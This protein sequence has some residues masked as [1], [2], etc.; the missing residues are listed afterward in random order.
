MKN[1]WKEILN[2]YLL[3]PKIKTIKI[4]EWQECGEFRGEDTRPKFEIE[5]YDST[6]P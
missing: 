3:N 5:K 6:T 4:T 2:E 1:N